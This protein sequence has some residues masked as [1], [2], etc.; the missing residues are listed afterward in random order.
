MSARS[1]PGAVAGAH[2]W[3]EELN[4]C[5]PDAHGTAYGEGW[6]S[7]VGKALDVLASTAANAIGSGDTLTSPGHC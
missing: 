1:R 6:D 2:C 3:V 4:G 7:A 5:A